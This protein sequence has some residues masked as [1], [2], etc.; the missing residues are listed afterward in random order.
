MRVAAFNVENL[1]DRIKAF[2]DEDPETHKDV[3]DAHA[4]LNKLFEKPV[5]SAADKKK[6]LHLMEKLGILKD[7]EGPFVWLR[8]I[9]GKIIVRPKKSGPIRIEASGRDDW[10]GWVELKTARVKEEA[11]TMTARMIRDMDAD[12]MALVEIESRPVLTEF[13]DYIYEPLA[14][15]SYRHLMV[16]DGN[17]RR[18]IDVGIMARKG[19]SI[20]SMRSHVDETFKGRDVFSRDCPEYIIETPGGN[21]IAVLPNH[22]K[23]KYGGNHKP[24]RDKREA[25]ATF[26]AKYYRRLLKEGIE[27]IIVLGDL[28]DTPDSAELNPLLKTSL[29]EI[30]DHPKFTEFE[31]NAKTKDRGIGTFATGADKKKIDYILLSPALWKRVKVGGIFRKGV[32]TASGRWEMYPELTKPLYGASDHHGLWVDLDID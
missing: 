8:K 12:I 6:M 27:N 14:G 7:D 21:K 32:W 19:F 29:K 2:N 22:F 10:V 17:D 5:Y 26:V 25:Q 23:S 18:G 11:I 30:T 9:R 4:A 24:S 20:P 16:I 15:N 13:H 28:N 31:F 3:L 1:F